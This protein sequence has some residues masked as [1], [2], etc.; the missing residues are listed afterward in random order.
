MSEINRS[1]ARIIFHGGLPER[2]DTGHAALQQRFDQGWDGHRTTYKAS[3]IPMV[4]TSK[5]RRIGTKASIP[6]LSNVS[7][8]DIFHPTISGPVSFYCLQCHSSLNS[9]HSFTYTAGTKGGPT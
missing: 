8:I 6:L 5:W 3:H 4:L 2:G 1:I 9:L 7:K